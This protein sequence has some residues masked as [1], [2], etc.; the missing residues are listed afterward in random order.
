V[1]ATVSVCVGNPFF[2][3]GHG[4]ELGREAVTLQRLITEIQMYYVLDRKCFIKKQEAEIK[5]KG[6]ETESNRLARK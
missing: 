4:S 6:T 2:L 3:P 5:E 1:R